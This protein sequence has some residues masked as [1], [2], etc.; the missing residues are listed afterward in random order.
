M[1]WIQLDTKSLRL[2]MVKRDGRA[3]R[4]APSV[5]HKDRDAPPQKKRRE[6]SESLGI[7]DPEQSDQNP[8]K[9]DEFL[10]LKTFTNFL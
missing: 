6:R 10:E 2:Q 5:F 9:T 3:L 1:S 4:Y 7:V 8:S